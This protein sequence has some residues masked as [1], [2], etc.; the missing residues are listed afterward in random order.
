MLAFLI[1]SDGFPLKLYSLDLQ[2]E[3]II[4]KL[5]TGKYGDRI[6]EVM[7]HD[8]ETVSE[9]LVED[10]TKEETCERRSS[11]RAKT[12]KDVVLLE[13]SEEEE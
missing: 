7:R 4:G 3:K 5:K 6:L 1:W 10:P 13:S 9:Q 11:K 12:Q 8:A 2:L